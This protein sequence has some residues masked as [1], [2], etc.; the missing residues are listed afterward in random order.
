MTSSEQY[1]D[2]SGQGGTTCTQSQTQTE[3]VAVATAVAAAGCRLMERR[4]KL[5]PRKSVSEMTVPCESRTELKSLQTTQAGMQ[6][7]LL[8]FANP[9]QNE[10][11]C[12]RFF[13]SFLFD[14]FLL[15]WQQAWRCRGCR[16]P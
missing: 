14:V 1:H 16:A 4:G 3:L 10:F 6:L 8:A 15:T 5:R 13:F 2:D 11:I 7:H 12:D 9:N